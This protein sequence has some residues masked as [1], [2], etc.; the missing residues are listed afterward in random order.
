MYRQEGAFPLISVRLIHDDAYL[1]GPSLIA[2]DAHDM[3][4]E[5]GPKYGYD[6]NPSKNGAYSPQGDIE[7]ICRQ[8]GVKHCPDGF[9]VCK[10]PVGSDSF[11]ASYL[12]KEYEI[13]VPHLDLIVKV[14]GQKAL[15]LIRECIVSRQQYLARM[16]HP[17]HLK[18][19]AVKVDRLVEDSLARVFKL[20]PELLD[21]RMR[22]LAHCPFSD[23]GF[24]LRSLA[25]IRSRTRCVAAS[26]IASMKGLRTGN[27]SF[28]FTSENPSTS[29]LAIREAIDLVREVTT[30]MGPVDPAVAS[31]PTSPS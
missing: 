6:S 7:H 9:L 15:A 31:R 12:D 2:F 19:F 18:A 5:N 28:D 23:G 13:L 30:H 16:L 17:R 8:R 20:D 26:L 29:V 25:R 24:G 4:L 22:E 27:C 3:F 10:V 21:A 1:F 14:E 11:I